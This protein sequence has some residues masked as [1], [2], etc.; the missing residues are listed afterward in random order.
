MKQNIA[1]TAVFATLGLFLGLM[2]AGGEAKAGTVNAGESVRVDFD[3]TQLTSYDP[4]AISN[5]LLKNSPSF[6]DEGRFLALV[7]VDMSDEAAGGAK[8]GPSAA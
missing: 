1:K 4:A 7:V 6:A 2:L 8:G 3:L 5:R